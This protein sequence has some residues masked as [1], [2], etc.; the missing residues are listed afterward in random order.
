VM[1]ARTLV[2]TL[3]VFCFGLFASAQAADPLI[4]QL[5]WLADA[6]SAGFFVAQAKEL[7]RQA[8]LDVTILPGGPDI[9]PSE[10]LAAGKADV[11]VDWMP[12]ALAV[13]D[14]GAPLVNIAQI[15]QHSGL[16]LACRRDSGIR[17]PADFKGKKI[18]VWFAGNEY[19]FLAWMAKLGLRTDGPNPDITVLRQGGGVRLLIKKQA[20]CISTM[21]YN[22]YGQLLDAGM[23]PSELVVFRYDDQGVAVLEDGLYVLQPA[24]AD[25]DKVDRLARFLRA[26]VEGWRYAMAPEHQ[27]ET[28]AIVLRSASPGMTDA[29][30]QQRML[31]EVVR[32]IPGTDR[33]IGYLEPATY[34]RTVDVLLSD[35]TNPVLRQKPDG[36]WT[37]AVWEKAFAR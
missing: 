28:V 8:G 12:S 27:T 15:F 31:R 33:G 23:K 22:E 34:Q 3:A 18:G 29:P 25:P 35:K 32:L 9:T 26:S 7:Y 14:K 30:H 20:D 2:A 6:Q 1:L 19:P 13:R 10:V 11:A 36:A 17:R 24:L 4:L 37:H 16:Q 21:T 5:K